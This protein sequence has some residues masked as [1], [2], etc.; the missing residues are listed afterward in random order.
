MLLDLSERLP[1]WRKLLFQPEARWHNSALDVPGRL[2]LLTYTIILGRC[3]SLPV[4]VNVRLLARAYCSH[5]RTINASF[6][7]FSNHHYTYNPGQL[8]LWEKIV[9]LFQTC[10]QIETRPTH[11]FSVVSS[12]KAIMMIAAVYIVVQE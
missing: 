4:V 11:M 9:Q 1:S 10:G 3:R 12:P 8:S 7:R 2:L 6:R 5:Y